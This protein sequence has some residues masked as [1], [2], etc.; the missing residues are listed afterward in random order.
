MRRLLPF[1]FLASLLI[2]CG[3]GT[4]QTVRFFGSGPA[5]VIRLTQ[6]DP[7]I[8]PPDSVLGVPL[9]EKPARQ[10]Q[11]LEYFRLLERVSGRVRLFPMG[12]TY[13]GRPLL[14]AVITDESHMARLE[15]IRH[16]LGRIA[17]PRRVPEA[18]LRR[19]TE[20][21]PACVWLAYSI[22]GDEISGVD[23]SLAVAYHLAAGTDPETERIRKELIVIIDPMENPDGR[24]RYLA[25]MESFSSAVPHADGQSFQKGGFWPWG[26]GN[27]YLFD[28][29]RDWFSLELTESR[30]RLEALVSWYPQVFVDAH[31]MGQWDTYL[32][33]PPRAPHNP[34]IT[35]RVRRWSHIFAADQ[36]GAFDRRGWAYYTREWNEEWYPGYGSSWP[37]YT[38]A[39]GILYEQAGITGRIARHDGTVMTYG[40]SVEHQYVSSMANVSTALKHRKELLEEYA[41]HRKRAVD[42]YGGGTTKTFFVEPGANPDR[43]DALADVLRRQGI[44]LSV[45]AEPFRQT[46]RS[47]YEPKAASRTFPKGTLVIPTNQPQGFLVQTILAFDQRLPDSVL[48]MERRELLKNQ[49]SKL[50]EVTTW[51]LPQA[52]G[53]ETWESES[54][55]G[56]RTEPWAPAARTG[57]FDR[58]EPLQGFLFDAGPDRAL[59]AVAALLQHGLVLQ[60]ARKDLDVEGRRF[61]RGSVFLPARSNPPRYRA[62]VDSIARAAG[63][64][65]AGINA[66]RGASGPDLGGHELDLL[67]APKAAIVAGG[68]TSSTSVGWIWHLL[69][70]KLGVPA[71]LIDLAQLG[72]LD[73]SIYNTIIL[74]D[75]WGYGGALGKSAAARLRQ[76]VEGGGTLIAMG[77]SAA[78]CADSS[79]GL[80]SVR[81]RSQV[82][83][84]LN[85]Y[86]LAALEETAAERPDMSPVKVWEFSDKDTL[87]VMK[88]KPLPPIDELKKADD[89][90]RLFS[91]RGAILRVNLDP[92]DWLAFGAGE[93]V[94]VMVTGAPVLMARLPAART[95]G[96]FAPP[97]TLR[98][99]GLLWPEARLRFAGTAYCTR[100]QIGQGQIILFASQP[101]FRAYFRGAERLL[102]NS[103]L[104]GPGLGTSWTPEW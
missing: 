4:A 44:E 64:T 7:R 6:T 12:K 9:G 38:G 100:E 63:L 103:V 32:F 65:V 97:A 30:A 53:L 41:K 67:R 25:Q 26:R 89:L 75:G 48:A 102:V 84:K 72:G 21:T 43:M 81:P 54:P 66:A 2:P 76:W 70:Q 55:A 91:P 79:S 86:E 93:K 83:A 46:A 62:I 78:Y 49:S 85:E 45:A 36:A 101:N 17:D 58:A 74:P 71:S 5:P 90:S 82:L 3:I 52:Y 23:A 95:V 42:D 80:S 10:A 87:A 28:M 61:P 68:A 14:Y 1:L 29:N 37:L 77:G 59:P 22:H 16:D 35:D 99:S 88:G 24:E 50:Y 19:L 27:H 73:L 13:E 39:V 94:P 11:V 98:I 33:S 31:E 56:V 51:S 104:F 60:V 96:R 34:F 18:E 92:E 47:Y 8:P 57:S 40:E 69:D 15:E 20:T